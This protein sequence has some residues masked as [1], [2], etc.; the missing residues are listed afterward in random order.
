MALDKGNASVAKGE[1]SRRRKARKPKV[2]KA[3]SAFLGQTFAFASATERSR[4]LK[5]WLL[6]SGANIAVVP[7]GDPAIV[8][9]LPDTDPVS[10]LSLIHI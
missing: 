7:E 5:A 10:L 3:A 6:D 1:Q 9:T 8:R 4:L 2:G